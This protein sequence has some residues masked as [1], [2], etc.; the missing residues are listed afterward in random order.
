MDRRTWTVLTAAQLIS[1][2]T[3]NLL[4]YLFPNDIKMTTLA[5]FI[6]LAD[7][8]FDL[9]N[10]SKRTHFKDVKWGF[11]LKLDVQ[12]QV[13]EDFKKEIGNLRV[14]ARTGMID[15]QQGIIQSLNA[16]PKILEDMKAVGIYEVL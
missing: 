9:V 5:K 16:L 14:G 4:E 2:T 13:I 7:Q 1:E 10:S 8:W 11:G 6:R 12:M 15:W 3:A